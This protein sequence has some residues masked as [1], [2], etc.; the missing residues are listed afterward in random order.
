MR[1]ARLASQRRMGVVL[2]PVLIWIVY[3]ATVRA[4]MSPQMAILAISSVTRDIRPPAP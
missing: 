2:N 3:A 4:L 1:L